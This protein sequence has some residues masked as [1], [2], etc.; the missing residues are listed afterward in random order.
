MNILVTEL[1]GLV[2]KAER[3]IWTAVWGVDVIFPDLAI[4]SPTITQ[5]G[6]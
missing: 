1:K 3:D 6:D 5:V 2:T 4:G